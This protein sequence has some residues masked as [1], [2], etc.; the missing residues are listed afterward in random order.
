MA[1]RDLEY[2]NTFNLHCSSITIGSDTISGLTGLTG[3]IG[4][5]GPTGTQGSAGPIGP[6][7]GMGPTGYMG[8]MGPTGTRGDTG[9]RGLMG[10][11]GYIGPTGPAHGATGSI[12]PTGLMGPTGIMGPTGYTGLQGPIGPSGIDGTNGTAGATGSIGPTGSTGDTGFGTVGP[13]GPQGVTGPANGPTGAMGPTGANGLDGATGPANGPTGPAGPVGITGSTGPA[14]GITN[15]YPNQMA[16]TDTSTAYVKTAGCV[17]FAGSIGV[18]SLVNCQALTENTIAMGVSDT[19][20]LTV[21][22]PSKIVCVGTLGTGYV[23]LPNIYGCPTMLK[24]NII[25]RGTTNTLIIRD[26][27]G[28]TLATLHGPSEVICTGWSPNWTIS[29]L[30]GSTITSLQAQITGATGG[31]TTVYLVRSGL[32]T[33]IKVDGFSFTAAAN[34]LLYISLPFGY[35]VGGLGT[36]AIS[37]ANYL[38][39]VDNVGLITFYASLDG[40]GFVAGQQYQILSTVIPYIANSL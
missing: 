37:A 38:V 25:N 19:V 6:T 35:R 30:S 31:S 26:T 23:E 28:Y 1:Y 2:P 10:Y 32:M 15:P 13:T 7:G 11:T 21:L 16:F 39:A 20:V 40:I 33:M 18:N 8:I 4:P 3:Y 36:T 5:I 9:D 24:Y 27:F 22:S 12:G 29:T 17:T 14:G 34:G